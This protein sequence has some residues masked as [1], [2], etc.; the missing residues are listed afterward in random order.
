MNKP[1]QIDVFFLVPEGWGVCTTC[2]MMMSQADMGKAPYERGLDNYPPDW[3]A[4]FER[5]SQ[6]I[7]SLADKYQDRVQITVW[8]PRSVRGMW[9]SI[10]HGVRRYPTFILDEHT[11]MSGFDQ[12]KLEE[13]INQTDKI[14]DSEI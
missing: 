11:K 8:D 3:K 6:I 9:K 13:Y 2:E 14:G 5:L 12:E 4:D 10:R 1:V 7:F